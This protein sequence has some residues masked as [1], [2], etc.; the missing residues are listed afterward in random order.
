MK[1]LQPNIVNDYEHR[2][3]RAIERHGE[4]AGFPKLSEYGIDR[5]ALDD[6]LF[7][8][9]CVLDSESSQKAHLTKLGIIAVIPVIV[10]S[11]FPE[12][13]LPFGKWSLLA[14]VAIGVLLA[15]AVKGLGM[16]VVKVRLKRLRLANPQLALF[17]AAVEKYL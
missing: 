6:Y 3:V 1:E 2:I 14:G 9:Q 12:Q 11:A 8:C 16:L 10:F 4:E 15:L 17:T 13:M 7:E 5:Q